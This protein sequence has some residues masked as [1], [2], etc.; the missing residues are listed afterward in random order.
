MPKRI[1]TTIPLLAVLLAT[2]PLAAEADDVADIKAVI[3]RAYVQG[4]WVQRDP[5]LVREGFAPTFVMQVHHQGELSSATL[6]QWLERMQLD[7]VPNEHEVKADVSVPEITGDAAVARVEL[8]VDGEHAYT[9]YLGLYRTAEGW[10][11]VNKHFQ[12]HR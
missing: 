9:D 4:V 1:R 3:D 5:D 12:S 7:R 10:K 8:R 11:I 2:L 6:D